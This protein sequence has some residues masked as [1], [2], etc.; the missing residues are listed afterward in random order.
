MGMTPG[1]VALKRFHRHPHHVLVV[2]VWDDLSGHGIR[3]YD[4]EA[5]ISSARTGVALSLQHDGVRLMW[6]MS[7]SQ[8]SDLYD[9]TTRAQRSRSV[10]A[11]MTC[12][13]ASSLIVLGYRLH[14]ELVDALPAP[15]I[16]VHDW[17]A[18]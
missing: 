15:A 13:V 16:H 11:V 14:T 5:A 12:A 17:A 3:V 7:E 10:A 6:H 2:A 18:K 9:T 1:G 4:A 8:D